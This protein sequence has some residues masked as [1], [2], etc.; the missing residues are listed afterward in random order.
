MSR[1]VYLS[2]DG[3]YGGNVELYLHKPTY[4]QDQ[5][6]HFKTD[7][8]ETF[9]CY[10]EFLKITGFKIKPGECKRVSIEIKEV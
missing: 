8:C 7:G 9:F 1:R 5:Q 4:S 2:R 10:E 6:W 3:L